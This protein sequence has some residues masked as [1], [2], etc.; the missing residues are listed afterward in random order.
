[1]KKT[2]LLTTVVMLAL[3]ELAP[4][5]TRLVP[6]EYTAIQDAINDCVDGDIVIIAPDTYTGDGNRDIDFLGKAITVRSTD[7]ND[8][9]VVASTIINCQGTEFN[10]HRAFYFH[11]GEGAESV[12]AGFTIKNGNALC[13][14]GIYCVNS[15]PTIL[16]CTFSDNMAQQ[17]EYV[18][19]LSL[20]EYGTLRIN[21]NSGIRIMCPPPPPQRR[22]NGAGI[23]CVDSNAIV[24][25]CKFFN[26]YAHEH[27]GGMYSMG[28]NPTLINCIFT[29]NFA[30]G[31]GGMANL[32]GSSP[33]L[34]DCTFNANTAETGGGGIRNADNSNPILTDCTFRDNSAGWSG[35]LGNYY[36]NPTLTNCTFIGNSADNNGGGINN[37]ESNPVFINCIFSNNSAEVGGGIFS[38][39]NSSSTLDSCTFSENTAHHGGGIYCVSC[40]PNITNCIFRDNKAEYEYTG[41]PP[42]PQPPENR[43]PRIN[44]VNDVRIMCPPPPPPSMPSLHLRGIGGGIY[45]S[46]SILTLTSSTFSNNSAFELGGAIYNEA[47]SN[48]T[49]T[50]CSFNGNNAGSGGGIENHDSNMIMTN[51][52]FTANS[53]VYG[54]GGMRNAFCSASLINCTFN[55]N[56][57]GWSGGLG[58]YYSNSTI[59]NCTFSGNSAETN[60]GGMNNSESHIVQANCIYS[61]NL[62][63]QG[64]GY[65]NGNNNTSI[66]TNCT[67]SKNISSYGGGI[68][69]KSM[70]PPEP[71]PSPPA[72][73]SDNDSNSDSGDNDV[74][75]TNCILWGNEAQNGGQIYSASDSYFSVGYSVVEG[76]WPGEGNIDENPYFVESGYWA[77]VNDPNS[78][79]E[80]HDP[81]AIWIVGDYRLQIGS[82]CIDAGMDAGIYEDIDGNVRPFNFPGVDNNGELSGFDIG[83][84]ETVATMQG[85]LMVIPHTIN[86]S[87]QRQTILALIRQSK[88]ISRNVIDIYEQLVV[89][90]GPIEATSQYSVP[91][92]RPAQSNVKI[93]AVIDK[94]KLLDAM[95]DNDNSEITVVGVLTSGEYFYCTDTVRIISGGSGL[96]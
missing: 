46:H 75:I 92:G 64:G 4:A 71:P 14:G 6:D 58:N 1:M 43:T 62:A 78:L 18:Y 93:Y 11:T 29:E 55:D 86:C 89:Y 13:G 63:L 76:G 30:G 2:I 21:N 96:R 87:S 19:S 68:Y 16:N 33:T 23:C 90:P 74:V 85:Q 9:N 17:Y 94:A 72:I 48:S 69:Y 88:E 56:Y 34:K 15:S 24:G 66:L 12:L 31:G 65:F 84:Y 3:F 53:A 73:P 51:C 47:D 7:P 38:E 50:K 52:T 91:T 77:D 28:G 32:E 79:V 40:S 44:D 5:A 49:L 26:N 10:Q 8:P 95:Q 25:N 70:A 83:A 54:G 82:P 59:M 20:P 67:F 22:G 37:Y 41:T 39:Y 36:S 60:G 81:N 57:A 35:G 27:G 80:P 42:P 45:C 61:G